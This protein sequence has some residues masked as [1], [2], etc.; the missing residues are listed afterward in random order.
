MGIP[1]QLISCSEN[2][3]TPDDEELKSLSKIFPKRFQASTFDNFTESIGIVKT[4]KEIIDVKPMPDLLFTGISGSGK[5]HLAVASVKYLWQCG[6]GLNL[7]VN[8]LRSIDFLLELKNSFKTDDERYVIEKYSKIGLLI[9]DDLGSEKMSE[10]S[11]TE[12]Y[13]LL[14]HR[15]SEL[16]QTI[17]TT[18]LS[19]QQISESLGSRLASRLSSYKN[20]T[21]NLPDYRKKR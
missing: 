7:S 20:I 21:I 18:N 11:I 16:K 17:L 10:W 13:A 5:T 19:L 2:P 14:E 6:R 4:T 9:F 1:S 3:K 8:F 12:I 15:Y